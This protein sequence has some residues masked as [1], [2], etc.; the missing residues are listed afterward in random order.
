MT[1]RQPKQP[2]DPVFGAWILLVMLVLGVIANTVFLFVG[3]AVFHEPT[4]C[5]RTGGNL[6]DVTLELITAVAVLIS[7]RR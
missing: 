7:A 1:E 4:I 5:A 3:C 2:W 6:R